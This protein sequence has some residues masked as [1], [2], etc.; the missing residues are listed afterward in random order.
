MSV[1]ACITQ[2]MNPTPAYGWKP[3]LP[4]PRDLRY[5]LSGPAQPLPA[6]AD[7]SALM[8]QVYNQGLLSSCTANALA[9]VV[10]FEQ[11]RQGLPSFAPSCPSRLYIYWFE[12]AFEGTTDSDCGGRLRD[13]IKALAARG[14]PRETHWAYDD[15]KVCV[16]PSQAA[17]AAAVMHKAL[18]Y[19]A[20]PQ[21]LETLKSVLVGGQP[22]CF[23]FSV[24]ESFESQEV[25][26]TGVM[27]MPAVGEALCGGHAVVAVGYSD[28][29]EA[30]KIR[31]SWSASWGDRGHVWMPYAYMV[32][33]GLAS[34]FWLV[35][36]IG[37]A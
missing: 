20:L 9:A 15:A 29:K 35:S 11:R 8:P 13:G 36:L 21:S 6:S 1:R 17:Q 12:R 16:E 18:K 25:A 24:Y 4:D 28:A 37:T 3:Q 5:G 27:P 26:E 19:E 22:F 32:S 30:F 10:E 34:D 2:A 31:N 23:G 14:V 33:P 7:L